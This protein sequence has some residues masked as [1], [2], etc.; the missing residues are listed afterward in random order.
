LYLS[1]AQGEATPIQSKKS[2]GPA[3]GLFKDAVYESRSRPMTAGDAVM[4]F[5]DGIFEVEDPGDE[6]YSEHRLVK[7]VR[8]RI[9]LPNARIF[10]E[11]LED[12]HSFAAGREF[13]DDVCLVGMEVKRCG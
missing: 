11:L 7:A 4:L 12:V 9:Q 2:Q 13:P 1:R 3:L 10:S 6:Q 5:T 8:Q